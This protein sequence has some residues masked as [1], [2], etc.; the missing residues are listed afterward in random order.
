[1][2]KKLTA[3]IIRSI[4]HKKGMLAKMR[5]NIG[6]VSAVAVSA[7]GLCLSVGVPAFAGFTNVKFEGQ[8]FPSNEGSGTPSGGGSISWNQQTNIIS[9]VDYKGGSIE[10]TCTDSGSVHL[11]ISGECVVEGG[12]GYSANAVAFLGNF[13]GS[14]IIDGDGVLKAGGDDR[15]AS[16]GIYTDGDLQIIESASV[17]IAK[18]NG[19]EES[20]IRIGKDKDFDVNTDGIVKIIPAQISIQGGKDVAITN[21][22]LTKGVL[23][24]GKSGWGKGKVSLAQNF[25]IDGGETLELD[26]AATTRIPKGRVVEVRKGG[27]LTNSGVLDN[28]GRINNSGTIDNKNKITGDGKI[29]LY[30]D[31]SLNGDSGSN[32]VVRGDDNP[33]TSGCAAG[34]FGIAGLAALALARGRKRSRA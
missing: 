11:S 25:A 18:T 6:F 17:G 20:G 24:A 29:Y 31:G 10:I 5:R 27:K 30:G 7:L 1:L 12:N 28:N 4:S 21:N 33:F 9:L 8:T 14:V 3:Q 13:N 26:S 16:Y 32:Q 22:N 34:T 2:K 19:R 23:F 15:S